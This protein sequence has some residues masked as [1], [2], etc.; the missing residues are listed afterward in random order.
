MTALLAQYV[1][2]SMASVNQAAWHAHGVHDKGNADSLV[3]AVE[4]CWLPDPQP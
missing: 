2:S 4:C 3:S 1:N